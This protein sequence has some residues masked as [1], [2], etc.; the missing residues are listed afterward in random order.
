MN[1]QD[2]HYQWI[3]TVVEHGMTVESAEAAFK[4]RYDI[5]D[6]LT[7]RDPEEAARRYLDEQ[8][9]AHPVGADI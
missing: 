3:K 5:N 1:N 8:A 7:D 9:S 2:W 4:Q 6:L